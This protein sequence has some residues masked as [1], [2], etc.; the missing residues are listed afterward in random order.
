[1]LKGRLV[2]LRPM[3]VEDI[4][5]LEKWFIEHPLAVSMIGSRLSSI[6][7]V[8]K[9]FENGLK[10]SFNRRDFII[11]SASEKKPIGAISLEEVNWIDRR[12]EAVIFLGERKYRRR[13][14]VFDTYI[15][16]FNYAFNYLNLNRVQWHMAEFNA[17]IFETLNQWVKETLDE[18]DP[19][20]FKMEGIQE[21]AIYYNGK[22]WNVHLYG[23]RKN[24][25]NMVKDKFLRHFIEKYC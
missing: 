22:Y 17:G 4:P 18:S 16:M 5:I 8:K 19:I 13:E 21:E 1:M 14:Y 25:Y 9:Y 20:V 12:A 24:S 3:L 10:D 15:I 23:I 11:E 2:N 6:E 7:S